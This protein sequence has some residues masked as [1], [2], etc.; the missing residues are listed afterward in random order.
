MTVVFANFLIFFRYHKRWT[1]V[2]VL[3]R[4]FFSRLECALTGHKLFW[5]WFFQ[6]IFEKKKKIILPKSNVHSFFI[7]LVERDDSIFHILD[8]VMPSLIS[9]QFVLFQWGALIVSSQ[10]EIPKMYILIVTLRFGEF[11]NNI[12][13][14]HSFIDKNAFSQT[15]SAVTPPNCSLHR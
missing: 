15:M 14:R 1:D 6:I 8:V 12:M 4:I 10:S 2:I 9:Y 5:I 11:N 13:R 3:R 7:W